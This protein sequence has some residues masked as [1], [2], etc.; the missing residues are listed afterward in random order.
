MLDLPAL[1]S[2]FLFASLLREAP[3]RTL[4]IYSPHGK[5]ILEEFERGFEEAHPGVDVRWLDLGA[6]ACLDRIR[7]E[8]GNPQADLWWGGP[9]TLFIRAAEEKLLDSYR[10]SWADAVPKAARDPHDLWF[11][12]FSLPICIA[13]NSERLRPE[14]APRTFDELLDP[15]FRGQIVI[16]Y[17]IESGTMRSFF[18]ATVARLDGPVARPERA[19]VWLR[20]LARN[21]KGYAADS[22]LLNQMMERG[23]ATVTVWN[24][25]DIVFQRER[26]GYHFETVVPERDV[27][28]IT[29]SLAVVKGGPSPDLARQFYEYAT[30][31]DASVRLANAHFRIPARR[32]IPIDRL[33]AWQAA[34]HYEPQDIDWI[35]L[36][37]LEPG[38]MKFWE[39][40]VRGFTGAAE[41]SVGRTDDRPTWIR[42]LLWGSIVVLLPGLAIARAT[43][44]RRQRV[45]HD[46]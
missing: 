46:V 37:K 24:L 31:I 21:T 18:S 13:Y 39:S 43:S 20:E 10:P 6:Q 15:R 33:P 8:R 16:R 36:S 42:A 26:Y 1:A 32:D 45:F 27:P 30:S 5:D 4:T 9:S 29:D 2:L 40:E 35:T 44:R 22:T 19:A 34:L 28:V 12:Q 7:A 38:W 41:G 3:A 11:G 17:P 14:D 23:E 25:T